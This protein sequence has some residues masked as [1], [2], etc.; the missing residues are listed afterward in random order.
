MAEN[1]IAPIIWYA[2]SMVV[3]LIYRIRLLYILL[4]ILSY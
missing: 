4:K 3:E 1:L 2:D